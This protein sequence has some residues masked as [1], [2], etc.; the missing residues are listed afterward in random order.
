[1]GIGERV[2][3]VRKRRNMTAA[4]L[5]QASNLSKGFISQV[6]SGLSNPSIASLRRISAAIGVPLSEMVGEQLTDSPD[7]APTQTQIRLVRSWDIP[8]GPLPVSVLASGPQGTVAV[9]YLPSGASLVG[10]FPSQ[11]I[12]GATCVAVVTS[13]TLALAGGGESVQL[14]GGDAVTWDANGDYRL[15]NRGSSAVTLFLTLPPGHRLP[16]LML[17]QRPLRRSLSPVAPTA[18]AIAA[19]GPMRLAHMRAER[20]AGRRR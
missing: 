19:K 4:A 17:P 13:G 3:A 11:T 18:T 9:C 20:A 14:S 10:S 7:P 16:V 2:R 5:A 6:E 1:M 12:G 15:E 8:G